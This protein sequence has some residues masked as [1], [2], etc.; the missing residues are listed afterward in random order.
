[1]TIKTV[2]KH[3][4][5]LWHD[6]NQK[7]GSISY[8]NNSFAD[9]IITLEESF[10]LQSISPGVWT[11]FYKNEVIEKILANIRVD[12]VSILSIKHFYRRK[13]YVF[14]KSVSWKTR[15]TLYNSADDELL[16]IIPTINWDKES[17]NFLLQLNDELSEEIDD[18]II[19]QA[20]HCANCSLSMMNGDK[21]PSL[22]SL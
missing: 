9:A 6:D 7:V 2:D 4:F 3:K 16:T 17:H 21:V 5:E 12:S 11:T 19:L 15:F 1:M 8:S 10:V 22:I 14:K 20:I 13:K 18:F